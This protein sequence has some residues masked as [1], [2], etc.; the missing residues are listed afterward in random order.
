MVFFPNAYTLSQGRFSTNYSSYSTVGKTGLDL[1]KP[2]CGHFGI[3]E[4]TT[5]ITLQ[6]N[7][8]RAAGRK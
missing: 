7:I 4:S 1:E 3:K 5:N 6:T 2:P 8:V